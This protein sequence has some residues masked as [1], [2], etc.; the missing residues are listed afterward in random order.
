VSSGGRLPVACLRRG[1]LVDIP[2]VRWLTLWWALA[3]HCSHP[4]LLWVCVVTI[5]AFPA[6]RASGCRVFG[7]WCGC[8]VSILEARFWLELLTAPSWRGSLFFFSPWQRRQKTISMSHR[9][10]WETPRGRYDEN[11]RKFSLSMKPKFNRPVGERNHFWRLLLA[12]FGKALENS[13]VRGW[14]RQQQRGTRTQYNQTTLPQLTVRL[15]ISPVCWKQRI[16]R[17]VWKE[18]FVCG[19]IK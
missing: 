11:I 9:T 7:S 12:D 3:R 1:S 17:I 15:S 14:R 18:M 2:R 4:F 19:E 6:I 5:I 8:V 13:L 10:S 16:R